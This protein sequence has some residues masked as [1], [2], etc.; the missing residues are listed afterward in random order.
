MSTSTSEDD[1]GAYPHTRGLP[2]SPESS[3][4]APPPRHRQPQP[5]SPASSSVAGSSLRGSPRRRGRGSG[6]G[7]PTGPSSP[8]LVEPARY[9]SPRHRLPFHSR[10]EAHKC[11]SMKRR[12]TCLKIHI[13]AR[14]V[15]AYLSLNKRW[16]KMRV[17]DVAGNIW[18]AL[19]TGTD[20]SVDGAGRRSVGRPHR[21]LHRQYGHFTSP[22]FSST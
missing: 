9:C 20:A 18:Q 17:P 14:R 19:D 10:N 11:V 3:N 12:A 21:H 5:L 1:V 4:P 7:G 6:P 15:Q 22:C 8:S 16:F 13:F 2:Q